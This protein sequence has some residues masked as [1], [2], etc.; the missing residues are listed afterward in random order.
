MEYGKSTFHICSRAYSK[1]VPELLKAVGQKEMY[2][3]KKDMS[4]FYTAVLRPVSQYVDIKGLELLDEYKP[5]ELDAKLYL[6]C[7]SDGDVIGRLD[8]IYDEKV[9]DMLYNK[10]RNPFC[11]YYAEAACENLIK[12]YFA[13]IPNDTE[14]PLCLAD[15]DKLYDLLTESIPLLSENMEILTT[16]RFDN[17]SVMRPVARPAVGV[18]P[19]GS[20][21]ELEITA[22]GV[23]YGGIAGAVKGIPT[24]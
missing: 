11:D 19:A 6:D 12:K 2:I 3:S 17:K 1:V 10:S 15:D 20:M 16:N 24:G 7:D 22:E 14:N 4:A 18:R 13:V 8:F 5:P 9:Y 21:L 23:Q